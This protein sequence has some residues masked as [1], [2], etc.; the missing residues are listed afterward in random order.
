M[1]GRLILR[2]LKWRCDGG[3]L[4]EGENVLRNFYI[5]IPQ[6]FQC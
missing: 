4:G 2:S 3:G 6:S 1:R 5:F